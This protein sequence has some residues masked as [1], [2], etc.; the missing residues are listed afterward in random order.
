M[1]IEWERQPVVGW[2]ARLKTQGT[3]IVQHSPATTVTPQPVLPAPACCPQSTPPT[4]APRPAA[5]CRTSC[6]CSPSGS[7]GAL[8]LLW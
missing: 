1:Q 4:W 3:G 5:T 2:D 8:L 7:G 6:A